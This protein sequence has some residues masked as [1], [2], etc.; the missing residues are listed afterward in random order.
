MNINKLIIPLFIFTIGS[1]GQTKE[2]SLWGPNGRDWNPAGR[3]PD[4]SYAG[5][6]SSAKTIPNVRV[7]ANLKDFG[8]NPNDNTDDSVK[9]Q[10]LINTQTG[11][12]VSNPGAILIPKG[13]WIID[14]QITMNRSGLVLRGEV[15][16]NGKPLTEFYFPNATSNKTDY[17]INMNGSFNLTALGK[18]SANTVQGAKTFSI[19]YSGSAK[20]VTGDFIQLTQQDETNESL[21]K[22]LHGDIETIGKSTKDLSFY[23][24]LFFWYAKVI[25]V[26]GNSITVD[27]PLPIKVQTSWTPT[28]SKFN[29]NA[30]T[31]EMGIE[32]II[33]KCNNN[34]AFV[35]NDY[36]GFRALSLNEVVNCWVKNVELVDTEYGIR[37]QKRSCFNTVTGVVIRDEQINVPFPNLATSSNIVNSLRNIGGGHHPLEVVY[38]FYNLIEKFEFK[39]IYWHEL[40]VEG[41]AAFNVF[42]NGKGIAVAF[43]NHRNAPYANLWT[44]IDIGRPERMW[45]NSGSN[46]PGVAG[47]ERGPHCGFRTTYWNV[48]Y[49]KKTPGAN[50]PVAVTDG[51]SFLNCIGVPGA[52][53]ASSP[54]TKVNTQFIEI[55]GTNEKVAQPDL[56]QA[57]LDKRT[58]T[59]APTNNPPVLSITA[60][61]S[62]DNF[63]APATVA[64]KVN[65]TENDPNDSVQNVKLFLNNTLVSIQV[66]APYD[67]N[68]AGTEAALNNL[69]LGSYILKAVATDANGATSEKSVTIVVRSANV[70]PCANATAPAT[71]ITSPANNA[72]FNVGQTVT[73]NASASSTAT[74]TKVEFYD[75][76]AL[77]ATDTA[78]PYAFASSTL[79]VGNHTFTTKAFT[80]CNKTTVSAPIVIKVNAVPI[81]TGTISGPSC[82]NPLQS[83]AFE[84]S[85]QNRVN[86]TSFNWFFRGAKQ[87]LIP[88]ANGFSC[89]VVTTKGFGEICV[90]VRYSNGPYQ[91][92]CKTITLCA[93]RIDGDLENSIEEV[94]LYPNP[95]KGLFSI[96]LNT[97]K[98]VT[99]SVL[100]IQGRSIFN[101]LYTNNKAV[102]VQDIDLSKVPKGIY[103]LNVDYDN[104]RI[105]KKII[106]E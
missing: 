85:S 39:N 81:P 88:S 40:S 37:I 36:R 31:T 99:I 16:V 1:F 2:S 63:I 34:Q 15:D 64:V 96:S 79:T 77:V 9:L 59:T 7:V 90:G 49:Q 12:S 68:L 11:V 25:S 54:A 43:D 21:A 51:F 4:F 47:R 26:S 84:L 6:T 8:A 71:T 23:P 20:F 106:I 60:P 28:L 44:N 70:D 53:K 75:G 29:V 62:T 52:T 102:F 104:K 92:F 42:R 72:N 22:H 48:A 65:A 35:H 41:A 98:S 18:I 87:S 101:E 45:F 55:N 17:H 78:T 97:S 33:L 94:L 13:R 69:A 50:L 38:G 57:Q 86:A 95:S 14:N 5:Y 32:N 19:A 76:T 30:S 10:Q 89:A 27:R 82:G 74:I 73:I 61:L 56:F 3:L 58:N 103:F 46:Q 100:D 93:G 91:E 67:W 66:A 24:K 80:N 105:E 83:L